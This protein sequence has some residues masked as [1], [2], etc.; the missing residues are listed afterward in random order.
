MNEKKTERVEGEVR[1]GLD[2]ALDDLQRI[3]DEVRLKLHLARMEARDEWRRLEPEIADFERRVE[4]AA[5]KSGDE[6][7]EAARRL[8]KRLRRVHSELVRG[9]GP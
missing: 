3:A 2:D 6:L 4:R 9:A 5:E 7:V 8:K 1:A